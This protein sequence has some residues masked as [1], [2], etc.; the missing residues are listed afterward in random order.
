MK[1]GTTMKSFLAFTD[2][3]HRDRRRAFYDQHPTIAQVMYFVLILLP[4]AGVGLEGLVGGALGLTLFFLCYY[5]MPY[6]WVATH[7]Q[8]HA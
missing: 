1:G 4:L 8:R 6:A 7:D 3:L 2:S 5:L